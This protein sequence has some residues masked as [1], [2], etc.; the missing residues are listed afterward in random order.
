MMTRGLL[1]L[2]LLLSS[3][4]LAADFDKG[5]RAYKGN[6][7]A[8]AL[9]ELRPLAEQ[10]HIAAQ[11]MLGV[12]YDRGD[13][14]QP[15]YVEGAR[16]YRLAAEQGLAEAQYN[17]GLM[18]HGGDGVLQNYTEAVHWY[19]MAAERGFAKAQYNLGLMY[20]IGKGVPQDYT[21]AHMW[22]NLA[23]AQGADRANEL[24]RILE[25]GMSSDQ[26]ATTQSMAR[27]C[28]AQDYKNCS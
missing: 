26:I 1:L 27:R 8:T 11:N 18:Y 3:P 28:R 22:G 15:N 16:W 5:V 21:L 24:V 20:Y 17:L 13:G 9:A 19:R 14:V 10:G 25:I 6:D 23:Q 4:L 7:Y 2:M 12:M